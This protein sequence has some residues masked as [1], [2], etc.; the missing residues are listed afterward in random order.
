MRDEELLEAGEGGFEGRRVG[1]EECR[2]E[3]G[4]VF[5]GV[6]PREAG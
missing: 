1:G 3:G 6:N 2:E 4:G 5:L